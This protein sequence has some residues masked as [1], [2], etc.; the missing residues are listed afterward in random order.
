MRAVVNDPELRA[1]LSIFGRQTILSRHTC[2]HRVD[3]L[4]EIY[5]SIGGQKGQP[6]PLEPAA[7]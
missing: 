1:E 7:A 5:Q 2:A 6:Q 3:E 4:M